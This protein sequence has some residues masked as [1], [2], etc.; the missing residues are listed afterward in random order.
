MSV[1]LI[2]IVFPLGLDTLGVSLALGMAGFPSHRR[3]RL[4]FL[5]AGF[6]AVMPL[7][8]V[9]LGAPLGNAIGGVADYFAGALIAGLGTYMLIESGGEDD[10]QQR[11]NLLSMTHRGFLGALALGIS[12]SLDELAIGFSAG[13]LRLPIL[14]MVIAIGVQAFVITQVGVRLG[15]HVGTAARKGAEK[16]AGAALV[17]L[18][19][20]LL[21]ERLTA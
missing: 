14:T 4:S 20:V 8:G 15:G 5:F 18:G 10:E 16:L 3:L 11:D 7:I 2:A 9:A 12:I 17:A 21:A 1:K 6:E 19:V 13:L